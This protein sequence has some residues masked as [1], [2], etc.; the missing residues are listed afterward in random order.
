MHQ[1]EAQRNELRD[2]IMNI[3]LVPI[4]TVFSKLKRTVRDLSAELGKEVELEVEEVTTVSGRGVGMDVVKKNIE[5]LRGTIDV[6]SRKGEGMNITLRLPLTLAIIDGL[7]VMIADRRFVIP[8]SIVKECVEHSRTGTGGHNGMR[9]A[10]VRGEMVPYIS[11]RSIFGISGARPEIEQIVITEADG[12]RVGFLVDQRDR[13]KPDRD[14][15]T[16]EH[17]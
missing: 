14:K 12:K 17:F 5:S 6:E 7:L 16:G 3:R 1:G 4:E 15:D 8:L 9:I 2:T 11:L 10:N 13:G